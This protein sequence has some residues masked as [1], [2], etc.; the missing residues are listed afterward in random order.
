MPLTRD[1][2]QAAVDIVS[3]DPD[4]RRIIG[5]PMEYET[6]DGWPTGIPRN[7]VLMD[8]AMEQ[9]GMKGW[10]RNVF[11]E[12]PHAVGAMDTADYEKMLCGGVAAATVAALRSRKG[13]IP[14]LKDVELTDNRCVRGWWH[15]ATLLRMDDGAEYVLDWH[16]TLNVRNPWVSRYA[17][18]WAG[19]NEVQF[20]EFKGFSD[21]VSLTSAERALV[22]KWTVNV[23]RW[24]W[25]YAF[26][27]QFGVTWTDPSNGMSGRGSWLWRGGDGQ[28]ELTWTGSTTKETWFLPLNPMDQKGVCRMAAGRFAVRAVK[29][30]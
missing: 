23:D 24:T 27:D 3:A 8:Q 1:Q 13:S 11:I 28:V 14:H 9:L 6:A 20:R 2:V 19:Q 5:L 12:G 16:K 25:V 7:V 26:D 30:R 22:G 18:W 15:I 4:C 17:D 29:M 21:A 10:M